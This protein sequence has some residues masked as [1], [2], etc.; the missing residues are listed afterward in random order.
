[1]GQALTAAGFHVVEAGSGEEALQAVLEGAALAVLDVRL[2]GLSGYEVCR[3]E[4]ATG[5]EIES[6]SSSSPATGSRR[7]IAWP[8]SSSAR[9]TT[10]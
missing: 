1:M 8:G 3:R 2:P 7:R 9:T 4:S 10:S 6:R 5:R